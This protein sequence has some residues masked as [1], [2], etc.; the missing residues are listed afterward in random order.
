MMEF[1][2]DATL[3]DWQEESKRYD[4][5]REFMQT[6]EE[7]RIV[8][9]GTDLS[10]KTTGRKYLIDDGHINCPAKTEGNSNVMY[11]SALSSVGAV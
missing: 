3:L 8:G 11:P 10:F 1:F 7:V 4:A 6:T 5:I 9:K 2:F